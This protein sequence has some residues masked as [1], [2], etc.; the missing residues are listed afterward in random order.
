MAHERDP[1]S[2][3]QRAGFFITG[4]DTGVGKTVV[5]ATLTRLLRQRG[6]RVRVCKPVAT[7]AEIVDGRPVAHDTRLLA[8]AA[9]DADLPAITPWALPLPASPPVAARFARLT[10]TLADLVEAVAQRQQPGALLLVEGVGGLLCPLTEEHTIADLVAV[11]GLPLL[12]VARRSLGTLNHT[13]LTL[14]LARARA[15]TVAGVVMSEIN[16]PLGIAEETNPAELRR[17]GVPLL[18]VL[19]YHETGTPAAETLGE[20]DW[21]GLAGGAV[22]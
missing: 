15:L 11:L 10:L 13:L 16:P 21:L 7:G 2:P 4:T 12:V 6:Q 5:T 19:P 14:E 9:G 8:E 3:F 17:L 20:V 1:Q 18:A 22:G